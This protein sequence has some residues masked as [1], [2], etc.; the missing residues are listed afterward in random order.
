MKQPKCLMLCFFKEVVG[1]QNNWTVQRVPTNPL[2]PHSKHTASLSTSH[3]SGY[4]CYNWWT[5]IDTTLSSK[6]HSVRYASLLWN[7]GFD[8]CILACIH[9]YS[10]IQNSFMALKILCALFIPSPLLSQLLLTTDLCT[11]S[12][13]L[14]LLECHI[15][16]ITQYVVFKLT[17]FT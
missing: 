15:V 5:Y 9:Y 11:G 17:S 6:V 12:I 13:I 1:S 4:T 10:I 14:S 8:K 3:T 2:H 7:Y 16:G